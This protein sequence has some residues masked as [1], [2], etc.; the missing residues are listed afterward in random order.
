M[1]SLRL[2]EKLPVYQIAVVPNLKGQQS[3]VTFLSC[4][5]VYDARYCNYNFNLLK[6]CVLVVS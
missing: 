4:T 6:I 2:K 5:A 1:P 3:R